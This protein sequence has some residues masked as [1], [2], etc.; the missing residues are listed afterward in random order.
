MVHSSIKLQMSVKGYNWK[1]KNTSNKN[2]ITKLLENRD[3][4]DNSSAD[5]FLNHN[6]DQELFDPHNI[7]DLTVSANRIKDAIKK[8]ENIYIFGDYDADGVCGTSILIQGLKDLGAQHLTF[9]LPNRLTEGYSLNEDAVKEAIKE[10]VDLLI[11][12]DCGTSNLKE[13]DQLKKAGI[14]VIIIDHHT[15]PEKLPE[16]S[17][18]LINPHR[19]D[20]TYIFED[21]CAAGLAYKLM[22][23]IHPDPQKFTTVAAI[24]TIA[25]CM[26]LKSENRL[27]VSSGLKLIKQDKNPGIQALL[28]ICDVETKKIDPDI[29]GFRIAP[30]LNA[31]GR[32]G[33]ADEALAILLSPDMGQAL[34]KGSKLATYNEM[35]RKMVSSATDQAVAITANQKNTH[36]IFAASKDWSSG[37]VGLIASGLV[38]HHHK[39]AIALEIKGDTM[40]ASCRSTNEFNIINALTACNKYLVKYGGHALAAGFTL[41]TKDYE[42]FCE[43]MEKY[44]NSKSGSCPQK[45]NLEIDTEIDIEDIHTNTI[46]IIDL[47]QP[48]GQGNPK[49]SFLIKQMEVSEI[50]SIGDNSKHLR[51]IVKSKG[52]TINCIGFSMGQYSIKTK[53][54]DL[55]NLVFWLEIN[56]FRGSKNLQFNLIDFSESENAK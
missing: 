32:L 46:K 1:V 37:I 20:D 12:C 3:I 2:L 9:R 14:D 25:D 4:T 52:R 7:K 47:L 24:A 38:N 55:L 51:M 42:V 16:G 41:K 22:Q 23:A 35:R 18:A 44:A 43:A 48:T 50:R 33:Y 11:T 56:E 30:H 21:L 15:I 31:A 39:P 54:G 34:I 8:N 28:K 49:P 27:I 19:K 10:K 5:Q 29:I 45:P 36:I 40:T 13:I 26:P 53:V 6:Y 17:L